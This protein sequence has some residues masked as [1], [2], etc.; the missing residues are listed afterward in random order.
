MNKIKFSYSLLEYRLPNNKTT[1]S[2]KVFLRAWRRFNKA[3]EKKLGVKVTG[4][5]PGIQFMDASYKGS[6]FNLS[7]EMVQRIIDL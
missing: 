1:A 2:L 6:S 7:C 4:F 3:F 5:N